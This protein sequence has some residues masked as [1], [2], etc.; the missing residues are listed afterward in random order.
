M[1][2]VHIA[3]MKETPAMWLAQ[4]LDSVRAAADAAGFRVEVHVID[5]VPGHIGKAR[6][7]GY[8][9][10]S[11][12]Y[13]AYVD[14]DDYVLPHAFAVL[15]DALK[16][17]PPAV[18]GR[19]YRLQNGNLTPNAHR[20]NMMATRRDC[21]IDHAAWVGCPDIAQRRVEGVDVME[22]GY[23][24]RVKL[25]SAGR[26]LARADAQEYRRACNG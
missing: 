20:H 4:C 9:L 21:L 13:A 26:A 15:A 16:A 14:D 22:P 3:V 24:Y 19:E 18:Y 11:Q 10:G 23:V 25:G 8:A 2:D 17:N 7:K 6:A 1:L 5:G 12:P